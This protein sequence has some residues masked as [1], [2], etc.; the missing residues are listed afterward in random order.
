GAAFSPDGK[1]LAISL[2]RAIRFVDLESKKPQP[3]WQAPDMPN[4]CSGLMYS[5]HGHWLLTYAAFKHGISAYGV[6]SKAPLRSLKV[7]LPQAPCWS[8]S[9][10]NKVVALV[11][12]GGDIVLWDLANGKM[13]NPEGHVRPIE[14]LAFSGDGKTIYTCAGAE[15]RAWDAASGKPLGRTLLEAEGLALF[16][17]VEGGAA[18][19]SAQPQ[20]WQRADWDGAAAPRLGRK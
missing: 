3:P 20:A 5:H 17:K 19:L 13:L 16:A 14:D 4:T 11:P 6:Q 18:L 2:S 10:D 7:D 1:T 15:A 9:P 8:L 12:K